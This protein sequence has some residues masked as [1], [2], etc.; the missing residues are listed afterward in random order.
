[1]TVS[2]P[3]GWHL[4]P[5]TE[6]W[7]GEFVQQDSPFA[8]VIYQ[9]KS[10]SPFIALA[11]QPLAGQSSEDWTDAYVAQLVADDASCATTD[12]ITVDGAAAVLSDACSVALV[13]DGERGYLIW[14]YRGDDSEWFKAILATIQLEPDEAVDTAP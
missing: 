5:A 2:Y 14:L 1:M 12:P 3:S 7:T 13:S 4:Q 11:S 9:K 10:D 8:D 6:P